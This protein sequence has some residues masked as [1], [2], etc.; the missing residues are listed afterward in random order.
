MLSTAIQMGQLVIAAFVVA[1]LAVEFARRPM[2]IVYALLVAHAWELLA[3]LPSARVAGVGVSP[4][5]VV[6]LIAFGAALIRVRRGPNVWQWALLGAIA[7][8]LVGA[9]RGYLLLGDAALLGFRAELYFLVPALFVTTLAPR[10]VEAVVTA[11]IRFG[12]FVT[13]VAIARW[14]LIAIGA[15]FAPAPSGGGYVVDRVINSGAALGVAFAGAALVV[16]LLERRGAYRVS[17]VTHFVAVTTLAVV[18]FAQHRSV[19]VAAIAMLSLALV[20][21]P[22]RWML[23]MAVVVLAA[24][25]VTAIE[26]AGLGDSGAVAESL[27]YAATNVGTWEWRLDR[28]EAV[29]TT[30]AAR[31]WEAVV[32]GS[33]YGY[34]WVTSAVGVW[35]VSPHNGFLQV[36]VRTGLLGALLVFSAYAFALRRLPPDSAASILWLWLLGTIVY[37]VPYSG[38]PLTGVVLGAAVA[39]ASAKPKLDRTHGAF[40]GHRTAHRV[41]DAREPSDTA[42]VVYRGQ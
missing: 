35:E 22:R 8:V 13:A 2:V 27:T 28:W 12:V 40:A 33:G 38:G 9:L 18:L 10:H 30:H 7:L 41:G 21:L 20:R 42:P 6:N 23:K 17:V 14:L 4:A 36:A 37:F 24:L 15:P 1:A 3:S 26:V 31:G 32:F 5:D 29:W 34:G 16:R 11:I 39:A 25:G 19:W